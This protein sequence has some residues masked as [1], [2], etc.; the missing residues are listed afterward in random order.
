MIDCEIEQ[1]YHRT[2][3]GA[4]GSQVQRITRDFDVQ[5][6]FPDKAQENGEPPVSSPD[7]SSDPN[8][9]RITGKIVNC[10]GASS[11]LKELVP[12]TA[13]VAIPFEF[14]KFIIGQ[15]GKEVREMMN[16]F[17]VNIRVPAADQQS[18]IILVSGVPAHVENAKV[19]LARKVEK[20]E[21]EK[22]DRIRRSFEV[23]AEYHPK[24][25]G[26]SGGVINKLREDYRVNIQLPPKG[27]ENEEVITITGLEADALA[28]KKAILGIVNQYE[29]MIK[30]EVHIDPRVHS[31]II[32]RRGRTIRKIMDDYK[33]DIRLPRDGDE[34][35]SLVVISG[36]EEAVMDCID[37][38][39]MLEEEFIQDAADKEWMQQYEKPNRAV[40]NKDSN[41]LPKEFK[42]SKAPWDVS[43][44]EAFP[45]LGGGGS[46]GAGPVAW[47]P[48]R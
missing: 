28:A 24:I 48:R 16:E 13:E 8:I 27:S 43:S 31:M 15:K 25:I 30:E 19:G 11:A 33:V 40:D 46:S 20:L 36:D 44:S 7:R 37:H 32:G 42:V 35:P 18:D 21:E 45:S 5:I 3:M 6:K 9:I 38:L 29:S 1:Q 23:R 4:K 47:G 14:H 26:R 2:V 41:K 34:D 22:E 17:D 39:K 12:I 10:E